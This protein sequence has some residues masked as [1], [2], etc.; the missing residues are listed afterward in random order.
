MAS[1]WG[2]KRMIPF[3]SH[4]LPSVAPVMRQAVRVARAKAFV[5]IRLLP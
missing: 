2:A 5:F 3:I 1:G 4:A